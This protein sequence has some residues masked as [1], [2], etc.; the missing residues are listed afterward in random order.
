MALAKYAEEIEEMIDER[1]AMRERR[2]TLPDATTTHSL[3]PG[4]QNNAKAA[5]FTTERGVFDV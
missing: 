2:Y 4:Q 3:R 5:D 1:M